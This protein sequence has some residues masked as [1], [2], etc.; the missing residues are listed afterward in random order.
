MG[1]GLEV[2][3]TT[4][5]I[6][7]TTTVTRWD[8]PGGGGVFQLEV[9]VGDRVM[10]KR[11]CV[12][13]CAVLCCVIVVVVWLCM[14]VREGEWGGSTPRVGVS[15]SEVSLKPLEPKCLILSKPLEPKC[16]YYLLL[17]TLTTWCSAP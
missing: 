2:T 8:E 9:G 17:T 13:C 12:L 15:N 11:A 10:G 4:H 14:C 16:L 6:V 1:Q 3:S 7:L 5:R